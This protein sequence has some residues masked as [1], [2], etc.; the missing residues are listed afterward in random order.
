MS[1]ILPKGIVVNNS[2]YIEGSIERISTEPL[3][4][5][6]IAKFWKGRTSVT[7]MVR[8]N[9]SQSTPPQNEGSSTPPPNVSRIT[10]GAYGAVGN[11]S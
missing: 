11:E 5:A 9:V 2:P 10:G 1:L 3:D 7:G 4:L 8:S 6:D